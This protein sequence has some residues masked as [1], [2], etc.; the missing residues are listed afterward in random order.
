MAY[1]IAQCSLF[2]NLVLVIPFGVGLQ[3]AFEVEND[4]KDDESNDYTNDFEN[5][6]KYFHVAGVGLEPTYSRLWAEPVTIPVT[7]QKCGDVSQSPTFT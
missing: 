2:V 4:P 7:L 1:T 6:P 5:E 3:F